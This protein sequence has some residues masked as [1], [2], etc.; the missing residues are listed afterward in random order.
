MVVGGVVLLRGPGGQPDLTL[1]WPHSVGN[2][3][4]PS[5]AG[6]AGHSPVLP[7][8]EWRG[9]PA[10][11]VSGGK[12]LAR[13]M[14]TPRVGECSHQLDEGFPHLV[15]FSHPASEWSQDD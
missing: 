10:H 11:Q 4:S 8:L 12:A 9:V 3:E 2:R 13:S 14:S 6:P 1:L 5:P 7:G 15:R